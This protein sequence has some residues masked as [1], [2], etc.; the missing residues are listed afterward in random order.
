MK[1]NKEGYRGS[2]KRQGWED[3]MQPVL[4]YSSGNLGWDALDILKEAFS[5]LQPA[6]THEWRPSLSAMQH[7]VHRKHTPVLCC[8]SMNRG[9]VLRGTALWTWKATWPFYPPMALSFDSTLTHAHGCAHTNRGIYTSNIPVQS[10]SLA[11]MASNMSGWMYFSLSATDGCW[12][13]A[14]PFN[15]L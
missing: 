6:S 1:S 7:S 5:L 3:A 11:K 15:L 4:S 12:A 10:P 2:R 13:Q 14:C 9:C 8:V